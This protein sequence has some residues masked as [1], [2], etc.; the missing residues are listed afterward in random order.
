MDC[1][2]FNVLLAYA[3]TISIS[4]TILVSLYASVSCGTAQEIITGNQEKT[5]VEKYDILSIDN[6]KNVDGA[7]DSCDCF[8]AL[9]FTLLEILVMFVLGSGVIVGIFRISTYLKETIMK[10]QESK[11]SL[12]LQKEIEMRQKIE[13]EIQR[14]ADRVTN[15]ACAVKDTEKLEFP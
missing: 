7:A 5:I 14:T 10:K 11:K 13:N 6:S 1:S 4:F 15:N 8:A 2:C 12:K 3:I 9:G